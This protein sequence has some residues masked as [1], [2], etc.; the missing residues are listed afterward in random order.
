MGQPSPV[1]GSAG[2]LAGAEG[3]AAHQLLCNRATATCPCPC[4]ALHPPPR[5][6]SIVDLTGTTINVGTLTEP[7]LTDGTGGGLY[8][9]SVDVS[10]YQ[11]GDGCVCVPPHH[12]KMYLNYII[13]GACHQR[14]SVSPFP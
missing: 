13:P 6:F 2:V 3:K 8:Q 1:R 5:R 10:A 4:S 7:S 14:S 12:H 9:I 11:T